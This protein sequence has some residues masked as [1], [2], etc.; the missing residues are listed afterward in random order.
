MNDTRHALVFGAS[1]F[2]GRHLI[3]ALDEAGIRVTAAT[4]SSGSFARLASWL[5]DHGCRAA[6]IDLRVDFDTPR[7]V[8]GD[9]RELD[10]VT[11]IYGCAGAYRWGMSTAEARQANVD[12]V[13]AIVSLA[14]RLPKLARVVHVSGYRVGG[15]DP[16]GVPW[17]EERVNRTYRRLGA[18]EASK[19]EG[20][21]V[22]QAVAN[23][24]GV[25]WSIVNPSSV[26]GVSTTGESD[27][28]LGLAANLKEIWQGTMAARPGNSSTFVPIVPV[29]YLARFMALLPSD[30]GTVGKSFWLLDDAT[31]GLPD[32]L[33]LVG[34][35]Y[36]VK[37]PRTRVPVGLVKRLPPSITKA[38]PETLTFLASDRYPTG[39]AE[40]VAQR[41]NLPLP[42][43]TSSILRWADHLAAHR[44]GA[45]TA[46]KS[47]RAF[48][49]LAGVRTFRIGVADSPTAVL[50]GLPVNADTWGPVATA[51]GDARVV[52]LPGL[53]MSSGSG[54]EWSAWLDA[55]LAPTR[56]AHLV[57]HSIG[58]AAALEYAAANPERV[59]QI[60][61]VAPFF[62]QPSA[63]R[64]TRLTP[65][66]RWYLR[67]VGAD[68]LSRKL[69]GTTDYAAVLESSVFD[70]RRSPVAANVAKLL[71][72]AA[73]ERWRAE[74]RS[75]LEQYP[76]RV[77]VIVGSEDGLT[78]QAHA[79]LKSLRTRVELT[80]I[81]GA[82]HHPQ[83]THP[84]VLANAI[85]HPVSVTSI[86]AS[87][88]R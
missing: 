35:H 60:T 49:E 15:Q 74:L 44:F 10:D 87:A 22:F 9:D 26:I 4:R 5:A 47:P 50:P 42:D 40:Q 45:V 31:P 86:N 38:D 76:G 18:Y 69:T 25:P 51:L 61:L 7:L 72:A 67:R 81:R 82:G 78:D 30:P 32:L 75:T 79:L 19:V 36:R 29:D 6:P 54:R 68:E 34:R 59:A 62:L 65:L 53:G 57:G 2:L 12:N 70:L 52:D 83:L 63:E 21:A 17:S 56:H 11:E 8:E 64:S 85:G 43:T 71:A 80:T 27:Q 16:A 24:L 23:E 77:H 20:D 13:R 37:V 28:Q 73:N 1:G 33:S 58:S 48:E 41:H 55:L 84:E 88:H 66:T 46:D 14:A 39:P 3:L